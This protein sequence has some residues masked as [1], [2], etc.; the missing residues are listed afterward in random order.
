MPIT[1]TASDHRDQCRCVTQHLVHALGIHT[2]KYT[3]TH[4]DIFA[5]YLFKVKQA[6]TAELRAFTRALAHRNPHIYI[7]IYIYTEAQHMQHRRERP[8]PRRQTH[9][10]ETLQ[11]HL[12]PPSRP[13]LS[14]KLQPLSLPSC[15][16]RARHP[17]RSPRFANPHPSYSPVSSDLSFSHPRPLYL[18]SVLSNRGSS[19]FY[20]TRL[21]P[22]ISRPRAALRVHQPT[23]PTY[24]SDPRAISK[25]IPYILELGMVSSYS[26]VEDRAAVGR[27]ENTGRTGCYES[28]AGWWLGT[29]VDAP[30]YR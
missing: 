2:Y 14:P 4:T 18:L 8:T 28:T 24:R 10:P 7:H 27:R 1:E 25:I 20:T 13:A 11:T 5:D 9:P 15:S 30:G 16:A 22:T 23:T 19:L 26:S 21:D 6:S 12:H 17:N 3:R 29:R